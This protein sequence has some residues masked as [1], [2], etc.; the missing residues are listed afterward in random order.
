MQLHEQTKILTAMVGSAPK[1]SSIYAGTGRELLD[2]FGFDF[3]AYPQKVG[4]E[5]FSELLDEAALETLNDQTEAG[6]DIVTDGEERRAHYVL[7]IVDML[8]GID[9]QNLKKISL[10]NGTYERWVP[11]VIGT[12]R[13]AGPIVTHEYA[14]AKKHTDKIVKVSLPGPATVVDCLADDYYRGDKSQLAYDYADAIRREVASLISA[15]CRVIQ[16]DDPALLRYPDVAGEWGLAALER[17]FNG[18]E[19][20][21]TFVVHICRGYPDKPLEQKGIVYKANLNYYQNILAWLNK[22]KLDVVS[23][24]GASGQLD[25]SVLLAISTKTVML[26]ILDVGDNNVETV[27]QLVSRGREALR[28]I[29]ERQLILSPD[30]GMLELSRLSAKA[31]LINLSRATEFLNKNS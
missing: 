22:S 11:Q 30:C 20:R 23:I 10:R 24:E 19:D 7:S 4:Q 6:I 27:E 25:L 2:N 29:P 18:Y 28:Y 8:E 5:K 26:G 12:L 13:Y 17:C 15:G 9:S 16:F 3:R 1:P 21:A 31:K 14:F